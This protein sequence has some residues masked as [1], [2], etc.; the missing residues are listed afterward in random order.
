MAQAA[1]LQFPLPESAAREGGQAA[2]FDAFGQPWIWVPGLGEML[3][4]PRDKRGSGDGRYVW[5]T[6][7]DVDRVAEAAEEHFERRTTHRVLELRVPRWRDAMREIDEMGAH[8]AAEREA[9]QQR[10]ASSTNRPDSGSESSSDEFD[11][12]GYPKESP[13]KR[14]RLDTVGSGGGARTQ[15]KDL[16]SK[17]EALGCE[18]TSTVRASNGRPDLKV[19]T[20][21]NRTHRSKLDAVRH[22]RRLGRWVDTDDETN[23]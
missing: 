23:E 6:E 21:D 17:L 14:R 13:R 1:V 16:T 12:E 5:R 11:A 22:L 20:P 15:Q 18:I 10:A 8:V 9:E 19:R 7:G 4:G 3:V 2:V